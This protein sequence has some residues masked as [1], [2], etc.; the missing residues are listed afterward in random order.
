MRN[1]GV[2]LAGGSGLRFSNVMPKQFVRIAGKTVLEHTIEIFEKHEK[3]D[4][5]FVVIHP[6]YRVLFDNILLKHDY[7]KITAVL[8]GGKTRLESTKAA[9]V[10]AEDDD[11]VIIHDAVRPFLS[12]R[13]I[14]DCI[15]ALEKYKAVDVA[16]PSAD[17]IIHLNPDQTLESIPIRAEYWRGQTPQAFK[18][19]VIRAAQ[20]EAER[21]RDTAFTD[22]CGLVAKYSGEK[23][24]VVTGEENNIKITTPGDILI[25]DR[26]FQVNM[27]SVEAHDPSGLKDKVLVI[28]GGNSGIGLEMK[29][30][31]EENG[32]RVY[33]TSRSSGVDIGDMQQIR[34]FLRQVEKQE[35]HID[36]IVVTAGV[37]QRGKLN[38]FSEEQILSLTKTNYLGVINVLCSGYD[39]LK[40]TQGSFLLFSSSSYTRGRA[41]YGLYS[42]AKAAIVNLMQ[43]AAEEWEN[44][45]IRVNVIVP[46]RTATR[47]RLENF[48]I[49]PPETLLDPKQVA[50][51]SLSALLSKAT[52]QIFEVNKGITAN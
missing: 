48:G 34:D 7:K 52:G 28:F 5:I 18:A 22:D 9:L 41:F 24:Y 15:A 14:D 30:I 6:D 35:G 19:G 44:D 45:R 20:R 12:H 13:I 21:R 40:K 33:S 29:S 11:N 50:K 2:I 51:K 31:A 32:A 49:E 37:L 27:K 25:A 3:I 39:Y 8:N 38:A 4:E 26:V 47:M 16:I 1:I 17:T 36:H 10:R 43:S 23:T 46:E 42:S